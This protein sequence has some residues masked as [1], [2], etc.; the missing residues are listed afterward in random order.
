MIEPIPNPKESTMIRVSKETRDLIDANK[1]K[2]ESQSDC[3][4]RVFEICKPMRGGLPPLEEYKPTYKGGFS[5]IGLREYSHDRND[6]HLFKSRQPDFVQRFQVYLKNDKNEE[7]TVQLV[8]ANDLE[9]MRDS[10]DIIVEYLSG[11]FPNVAF[12]P[13]K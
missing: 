11:G 6:T 1:V 8:T 3:I 12:V 7:V 13:N 4:K 2:G 5:L 9:K 10:H